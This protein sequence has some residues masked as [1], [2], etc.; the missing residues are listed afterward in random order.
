MALDDSL[1]A[2]LDTFWGHKWRK[3][4]A[5]SALQF[6]TECCVSKEKYLRKVSISIVFK[7]FILEGIG[8]RGGLVKARRPPVEVV[9]NLGEGLPVQVSS[10]SSD[11]GSRLRGKSKITLVLLQKRDVN[12]SKLNLKE[13]SSD[14]H[15]LDGVEHDRA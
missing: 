12:I 13:L 9:R 2:D 11:S 4:L 10:M 5:T 8:G 3:E 6:F 7:H 14:S 1:M 15:K